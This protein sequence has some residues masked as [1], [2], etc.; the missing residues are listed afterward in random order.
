VTQR[1]RRPSP[2]DR[3]I[4][5]TVARFHQVTAKQLERLYFTKG[6]V[7]QG[8]QRVEVE[9]VPTTRAARCRRALA[10]LTRWGLVRRLDR[11][12]GGAPAGSGGY[13][14]V[15]PQSRS[16]SP[17][18][19]TLDI[20]EL[21]VRLVEAADRRSIELLDFRAEPECHFLVGKLRIEPDAYVRLQAQDG[22]TYQ[23]F[24]EVDRTTE[25]NTELARKMRRYWQA[26]DG[27]SGST[28][29][30][31]L[32]VMQEEYRAQSVTRLVERLASEARPLFK[33]VTFGE[34]LGV[35]KSFAE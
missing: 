8:R 17:D 27:W 19:H 9:S 18:D 24:A 13:V 28:F 10:R 35:L 26:Y 14:Y 12:I 5:H 20:A 32:F 2:R 34:A 31:V 1:T 22:R 21:Y 3:A 4:A 16:R 30:R 7:W 15:P 29:P 6:Y 33:V 23:W 11:P 25:W